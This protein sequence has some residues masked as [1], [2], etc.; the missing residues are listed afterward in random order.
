MRVVAGMLEECA[1]AIKG[2]VPQIVLCQGAGISVA[3]LEYGYGFWLVL[4]LLLSVVLLFFLCAVA[5]AVVYSAVV[6]FWWGL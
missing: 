2:G 3:F 1:V 5:Y 4:W 6:I